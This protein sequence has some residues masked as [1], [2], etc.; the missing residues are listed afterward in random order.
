MAMLE[1]ELGRV[2]EGAWVEPPR[3]YLLH[4]LDDDAF[5]HNASFGNLA[6]LLQPCRVMVL[7]Y[8]D[9]ADRCESLADVATLYIRRVLNDIEDFPLAEGGAA[10]AE[11]VVLVGYGFGAC[12]AH[13]MASQFQDAGREVA[14]VLLDSDVV[15]LPSAPAPGR[16]GGYPWLG[17]HIEAALLICRAVG[18]ADF[19]R[20]LVQSLAPGATDEPHLETA[21]L[22]PEEEE[23]V[24]MKVFW[25]LAGTTG[26]AHSYFV[27]CVQDN[28]YVLDRLRRLA[29]GYSPPATP[30]DGPTLLAV[31]STSS[32]AGG[33]DGASAKLCSSVEAVTVP[34]SHFDL[35]QRTERGLRVDLPQA[36]A[37]FLLARGF[38]GAEAREHVV[39]AQKAT[40]RAAG[41][42]A[43]SGFLEL[44][45]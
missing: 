3:V 2:C 10:A 14:L 27:Q 12:I 1:G 42:L 38:F 29:S 34:G 30:F 33:Q 11:R 16:L 39:E 24:L 20:A 4:G 13:Q 45:E 23:E 25:E 18:A 28:G 36:I 44:V 35:C 32:E 19:A 26:M 40:P 17:G 9:G 21:A 22:D 7:R 31:A 37:E 5:R 15:W 43:C 8:D 6:D 41:G